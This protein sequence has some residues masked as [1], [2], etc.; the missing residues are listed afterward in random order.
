MAS[1]T[2]FPVASALLSLCVSQ[3]LTICVVPLGYIH[4][5]AASHAAAAEH[6]EEG[7]DHVVHDHTHNGRCEVDPRS[8]AQACEKSSV[9]ALND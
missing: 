8:S 2:R 6:S 7:Q 5:R 3:L 9:L 1:S 4:T